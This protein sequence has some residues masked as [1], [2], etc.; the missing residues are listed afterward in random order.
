M[1]GTYLRRGRQ[2][3][4]DAIQK[5]VFE[6]IKERGVPGLV[7]LH[8]ANGGKRSVT[9]AARFKRM[10]VTPGAPDVLLWHA[11]RSYALELKSPD[12]RLSEAQSEMLARLAKAGVFTC[13]AHGLDR[14]LA[15]LESWNLLRGRAL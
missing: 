9:E 6:H 4:E 12:G 1:V 3:P 2:R 11:D 8:P 13:V 7:A 5:A 14:A 15:V 10:G